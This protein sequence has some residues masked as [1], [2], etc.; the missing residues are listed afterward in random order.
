MIEDRGGVGALHYEAGGSWGVDQGSVKT[1]A[2]WSAGGVTL[3]KK[4]SEVGVRLLDVQ[5]VSVRGQVRLDGIGVR[6]T[7]W[8]KPYGPGNPDTHLVGSMKGIPEGIRTPAGFQVET[9]CP[10]SKSPV[11]EIVVTLTKVGPE[12]GTLRGLRLE[13]EADG[14]AHELVLDFHFGICGTGDFADSCVQG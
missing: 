11:G 8:N 9:T 2:T 3:C 5:A 7:H 1:G 14:K 4:S 13:Y 10:N 12:G 6:T